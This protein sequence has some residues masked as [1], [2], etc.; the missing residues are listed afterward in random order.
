MSVGGASGSQGSVK[1]I[2]QVTFEVGHRLTSAGSCVRIRSRPR[3]SRD[4]HRP[5]RDI[6]SDSDILEPQIGPVVKEDDREFVRVQDPRLTEDRVAL[7]DG[8]E[9]V[10]RRRLLGLLRV[11]DEAH[12]LPAAG[13]GLGSR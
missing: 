8:G 2:L 7:K 12:D 9:R 1:P 13:A 6:Q 3:W 5:D 10:H 4:F 11:E